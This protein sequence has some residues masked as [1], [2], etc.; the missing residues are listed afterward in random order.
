MSVNGDYC[1]DK[2][3]HYLLRRTGMTIAARIDA[4]GLFAC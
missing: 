1:R 4:G 2:V 3:P